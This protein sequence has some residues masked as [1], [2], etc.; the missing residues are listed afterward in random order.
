MSTL[1]DRITRLSPKR[2]TLLAL[3][4]EE[5]L[6]ASN[7][8]RQVPI[9]V[10][11][12]GCR[13]PGGVTN[14]EEYWSLL[15]EGRD[16]IREVPAD[17][18]KIDQ[19]YDPDPDAP[20]M[21]SSR[22]GG[23]LNDIR[24]FDAPFFG[25]SPR[26]ATTM[27]PQQRILLE[28]AWEALEHSGINPG[29]LNG[30][31]TGVFVGI[32]N[33]DYYQ[34]LAAAALGMRDAYVATGNAGS[35][36]S[37]RVSYVLGLQGPSVSVDTACS[38]SLVAVHLACQSLRLGEARL[39]LA[40]GVNVI[41]SPETTI[42]LSKAHMMAPD[43][44][45][46]AFDGRADGFVRSEGCGIVVLKR[47]SDA[48][49][50]GDR[51][52]AVLRGSAINQDGRSSGITAPN[53]PSQEAVIRSALT[54]AG[55]NPADVSYVETHG[56]GTSL[57]DP[58]E[59]RALN[60]VFAP[61]RT[62]ERALV[63]GSVKTNIGHLES[64]AGVAGLMKV[65]LAL[66]HRCVPPHLHLESLNSHI[67]WEMFPI[68]VSRDGQAWPAGFERRL[69]GV[70]SFGF[71][72]TNAHVI[73]E[74]AP[75]DEETAARAARPR[76]V[77]ALSAKTDAAL[78]V[79]VDRF[80]PTLSDLPAEAV[81]DICHTSNTGRGQMARRLVVTGETVEALKDRLSEYRQARVGEHIFA[82]EVEDP[83]APE[84]VFLFS[85]QGTQYPGMAKE[86]YES[87]S[88]FKQALDRCA[89]VFD[90]ELDVPLHEVIFGSHTDRL[91][92]T[93]LTQPALFS[94]EYALATM[95]QRWGIAPA[96]VIGHSVGEFAAA[97]IAGVFSLE[98]AAR[99]V[100]ARGRLM[101][102]LPPGGAMAAVFT[103][104]PAV[105]RR[106][107]AFP[108]LSIA[109]VNAPTTIIVSGDAADLERL[110]QQFTEEGIE[111]R[112]LRISNAFHS[113]L[114]DP[115]LDEMERIAN[116]VLY[117]A[118]EVP[119]ISNLTGRELR[120]GE[121]NAAYW[122]RHL[123][124]PVRFSDAMAALPDRD[125]AFLE[126]GPG[127]SLLGLA[128]QPKSESRVLWLPSI[129]R[130][131]NEWT[132]C[133][134][135][136][137]AL[138]AAGGAVDWAAFD[139]DY[140][141]RKVSLPTYPF[142]H[143]P[144]WVPDGPSGRPSQSGVARRSSDGGLLGTRLQTATP[145]FEQVLTPEELG[146][147]TVHRINGAALVAAPFFIDVARSA[148][149]AVL[150]IRPQELSQLE[151][152][153]PL[154]ADQ[155]DVRVQTCVRSGAEST[156]VEIF[157]SEDVAP[158]PK[159]L[160]HARA[161]VP[162]ASKLRK[163]QAQSSKTII[164]RCQEEL[165]AEDLHRRLGELG[166]DCEPATRLIEHVWHRPG[167][168][169]AKLRLAD[170]LSGKDWRPEV[171][172]AI[173]IVTAAAGLSGQ[174]G[175]R[176]LSKLTNLELSVAPVPSSW[177][178]AV[179][180]GADDNLRAEI[181]VRDDE[182][183]E[184]LY[185]EGLH[186]A[187]ARVPVVDR[188]INS[189]FYDID[190][191]EATLPSQV[192]SGD[193][194]DLNTLEQEFDRLASEEGLHKY[195]ELMAPLEALAT[196][197]A[198]VALD[199][200]GVFDAEGRPA[201]GRIQTARAQV[202]KRHERLFDRLVGWFSC[203]EKAASRQESAVPVQNRQDLERKFRSFGGE[204]GLLGR[205]GPHL[206]NALR[207]RL[208]PLDLLF[209]DPAIL[210]RLYEESPFART[211]NAFVARV[212]A[213]TQ[214][215]VSG[216]DMMRVLEV[217][218]GTGG[219]TTAVLPR[220][221]RNRTEYVFTDVSPAFLARA[222]SRYR[223]Y[224]FVS[225]QLFDVER[226]GP[227]QNLEPHSFHVILAANVLHA[228]SDLRAAL[229]H[230]HELLA[231][232]GVL[233]LVE[234]TQPQ[235]WVDLTFGL[236]EGWWRFADSDVRRDYPL[237]G[238]ADWRA[239]LHDIG[240]ATVDV[241]PDSN[242]SGS[243]GQVVIRAKTKEAAVHRTPRQWVVLASKTEF[244]ARIV[245]RLERL[246][247]VVV[248]LEP[249]ATPAVLSAP[250]RALESPAASRVLVV[251][252]ENESDDPVEAAGTQCARLCDVLRTVQKT[253]DAEPTRVWAITR[254]AQAVSPAESARMDQAAL[255]GLGQSAALE[256]PETWGGVI[257]L[258]P[259]V[260]ASEQVDLIIN[261]VLGES[262]DDRVSYRAGR[263]Y[264]PRLVPRVPAAARPFEPGGQE[265]S[266]LLTGGLG[267]LGLRV[268]DWLARQGVRHLV[269]LGRSDLG[270]QPIQDSE[271]RRRNEALDR[272]TKL[273]VQVERITADVSD[274][275]SIA[276]V[277]ARFGTA[278]PRLEG[279]VHTAA[280]FGSCPL[281]DMTAKDLA[282]MFRP[283]AGGA[284]VLHRHAPA[285]V[286]HL[287][288]FSS[289]A[290]LIG[291]SGQAHYAAANAMLDA[292]AHT[293]RGAGLAALSINWG[294]WEDMRHT[295]EDARRQYAA[296]GL[297][298]ITS[299]RALDAMSLALESDRP[300]W[301]VASIDWGLLKNAYQV[302]RERPFLAE[303]GL[304][305]TA[306][307]APVV[308]VRTDRLVDRILTA[309]ERARLPIAMETVRKHAAEILEISDVHVITPDQGLFE[310]GMD[311]LMSVE[312]KNR[313]EREIGQ[314][315]PSTLTFNYPSV[316]ALAGY[317]VGAAAPAAAV[318]DPRPG[319]LAIDDLSEDDLA[320]LLS[321]HLERSSS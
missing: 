265:T 84:V 60:G 64:A 31:P 77:L 197:Y 110:R 274:A 169:L 51:I 80:I 73:V 24:G 35:V 271:S 79:L 194:D 210:T 12:M 155:G 103:D 144:Y 195:A 139:E 161:D 81:A 198:R 230:L 305:P 290:S 266:W 278:W 70:S 177:V 10:I 163:R 259:G 221:N 234:G 147:V 263:R 29:S 312:L 253:R 75:A 133:L 19:F 134:D 295:T 181:H 93:N 215:N 92:Q 65:I 17:R 122:R 100:A 218:A 97:A 48:L 143:V 287:V 164:G 58:I 286:E 146:T 232:G 244:S 15:S 310:M 25:I 43:G 152:L 254:G 55:V 57:G 193:R 275:A 107:A 301:S 166:I 128:R 121:M 313:L 106:I 34:R 171:L 279:I 26:E 270:A 148:V 30:S 118:P 108:R 59:V 318:S 16:A 304:Q 207:G 292:L 69:A 201:A 280:T 206:A 124:E 243:V 27:D 298:R 172:D 258:D 170:D 282:N 189:L 285:T 125:Y 179:L 245:G 157:A 227:S 42:L 307:S 250:L 41:C 45:C 2:L 175:L 131:R 159:W 200:L 52:L 140:R 113:P 180:H 168:A 297:Q 38:S 49:A 306:E 86:L 321:A 268:A 120:A 54:S 62:R 95:W 119:L 291:G 217:G 191:R 114:V 167:E 66:Q 101:H 240:F 20:G 50:D 94:V 6:N 293:R 136:L 5:R 236:T 247:D 241:F 251:S 36:I 151:L 174:S 255:W 111:T 257:D 160:L 165:T 262:P 96:L 162:R 182:G 4:L 105:L 112:P 284:W 71:S 316:R 142:Q 260:P 21:M 277:L 203:Q 289:T 213:D 1:A 202:A 138:Y 196:E 264:L 229:N 294:L 33:S 208:D 261:E 173:T 249:S 216:A 141:C 53:G 319:D 246:G 22:F 235:R 115:I 269:L 311:S 89:A 256:V 3:E 129:R 302:R 37:G 188:D 176:V 78:D 11:G 309:D 237:L 98:E 225:H 99:L 224:P 153:A 149:E 242:G 233:V 184:L 178:H 137:G 63:I 135:T 28:V 303:V 185:I 130:G 91:D 299:D 283:K 7:G 158:E 116:T 68:T 9:A 281:L 14:A 150:G 61:S 296:I 145:I 276:P 32:C 102:R 117:R 67:E 320:S 183:Q 267:A 8:G 74:E 288:L 209:G 317:L 314:P 154:R 220:L 126:V 223:D 231:P 222:R 186:L 104:E 212:I 228:T 40:G 238:A 127:T 272:L 87:Q 239:R 226:T 214:G 132:D 190:W 156:V 308:V 13:F 205:C 123:R 83:R 109:A 76:H 56:T 23:F 219:T 39:A 199:D 300:Q 248:R 18:W 82:T 211:L 90:A 44:R 204:I 85:G 192:A 46:K 47:L 273:G 252:D 88:T 72:G 315:L 187:P